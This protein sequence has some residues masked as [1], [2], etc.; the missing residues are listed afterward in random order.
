MPF[1]SFDAVPAATASP[2][3]AICTN[4]ICSV[5]LEKVFPILGAILLTVTEFAPLPAV[6]K[7][8]RTGILEMNPLPYSTGLPSCLAWSTYALLIRDYY[9]FAPNLTGTPLCLYYTLVA[10]GHASKE[11]KKW[12]LLTCVG[13][14]TFI[15]LVTYI[16]FIPLHDTET[17]KTIQG[18]L[19]ML[20]FMLWVSSPLSNVVNVI[21]ERNASSIDVFL[22]VSLLVSS[23]FWTVYGI[24]IRDWFITASNAVGTTTGAIQVLCL[25]VFGSK[26]EP[27]V[28]VEVEGD[29]L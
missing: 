7:L 10:Y 2:G 5:F 25:I 1:V 6:I 13:S 15:W 23:L 21:K 18:V 9:V 26:P 17:G 19:A 29:K 3:F 4:E 8:D 20:F 14:T 11:Q 24:A 27:S 16:C 28:A 22:A 12:M